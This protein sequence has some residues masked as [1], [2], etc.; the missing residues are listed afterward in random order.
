MKIDARSLVRAWALARDAGRSLFTP[1]V[2]DELPTLPGW[3]SVG[4]PSS[5]LAKELTVTAL[6]ALRALALQHQERDPALAPVTLVATLPGA[7]RAVA[8]TRDVVRSMLRG[9]RREVLL[10]G[11]SITDVDVRALLVRRGLEGVRVTVVGDRESGDV[12]ALAR[13]WPTEATPLTA[14]WDVVPARDE[15]RRMHGKVLVI[16]RHV[17]LLGSANFS[18]SGLGANLE[19]GVRVE[20]AIAREVHRT[21]DALREEAWLVPVRG[22]G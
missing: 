11:F 10:V 21:V 12:D 5:G 7:S 6:E 17:A 1:G 16:D 13:S 4:L 22:A 18:T 15:R 2:S 19:F 14:L 9:A 20:G 8:A 3:A